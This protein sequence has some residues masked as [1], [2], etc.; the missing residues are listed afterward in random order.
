[1]IDTH[2]FNGQTFIVNLGTFE[3][4]VQK[5]YSSIHKD[6]LITINDVEKPSEEYIQNST[7]SLQIHPSFFNE[8][9]C[10]T[11]KLSSELSASHILSYL[12]FGTDALFLPEN[13]SA[14]KV[15]SVIVSVRSRCLLNKSMLSVPIKVNFSISEIVSWSY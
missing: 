12:V 5:N 15:G 10:D 4:A 14:S 3:E 1:M 7:A 6:A 11:T 8:I 9:N 13:R 2:T